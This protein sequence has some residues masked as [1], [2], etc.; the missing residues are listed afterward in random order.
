MESTE[1]LKST[2]DGSL[3]PL[4]TG[5]D[6]L[7]KK[8]G[9]FKNVNSLMVATIGAILLECKGNKK[10]KKY[11]SHITKWH[12][13][14]REIDIPVTRAR[15][16]MDIWKYYGLELLEEGCDIE[17]LIKTLPIIRKGAKA[18][19]WLTKAKVLSHADFNNEVYMTRGHRHSSICE[20]P[21]V[22]EWGKCKD[23]G[24]WLPKEEVV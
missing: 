12:E 1:T 14:L 2:T 5:L 3:N 8:L 6:E 10:Y 20:H 13:F 24:A 19:D 15:Q 11:A 18:E 23:C 4:E 9:E 21:H 17:K 22:K 7:V 16:Y